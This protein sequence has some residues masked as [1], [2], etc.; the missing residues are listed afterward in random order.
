MLR[1]LC[2]SLL[3]LTTGHSG[4]VTDEGKNT[5]QVVSSQH[6]EAIFKLR[7]VASCEDLALSQALTFVYLNPE[8]LVG[9][10]VEKPNFCKKVVFM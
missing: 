5:L 8:S 9:E 4:R 6:D 3:P 10:T 1:W 7:Q 2:R